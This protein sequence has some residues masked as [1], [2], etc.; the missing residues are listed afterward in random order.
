MLVIVNSITKNSGAL[1]IHVHS[2]LLSYIPSPSL[3][4]EITKPMALSSNPP[5]S[6]ATSGTVDESNLIVNRPFRLIY[7]K[8]RSNHMVIKHILSK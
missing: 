3:S 5:H 6:Q 4:R 2:S 1:M 8:L 7:T